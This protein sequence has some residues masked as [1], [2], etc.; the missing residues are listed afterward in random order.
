[1][2]KGDMNMVNAKELQAGNYSDA[3]RGTD[4]FDIFQ[5]IAT[6][7]L[8]SI[9]ANPCFHGVSLEVVDA[10]NTDVSG[11]MVLQSA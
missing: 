10:L 9:F 1:M 2:P 4:G 8:A 11:N 6:G 7:G 3:E 5:N